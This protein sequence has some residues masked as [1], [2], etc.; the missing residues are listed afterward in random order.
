MASSRKYWKTIGYQGFSRFIA[1]DADFFLLRRLDQLAAW[2]LLRRQDE[3]VE[4]ESRLAELEGRLTKADMNIYN[5]SFRE[6]TQQT[7]KDLLDEI[8]NKLESYYEFVNKYTELC[9]RPKVDK[10]QA[11]SVAT[12]FKNYEHA[13]HKAETDYI[14]QR[15]DLFSIHPLQI[16]PPTTAT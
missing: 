10:I 5:G 11:S 9:S 7:R 12:W 14:R 16:S 2:T 6:E 15:K 1:S 4:L 8:D 13:I 3:I